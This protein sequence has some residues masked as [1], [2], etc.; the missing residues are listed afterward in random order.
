MPTDLTSKKEKLET[1]HKLVH[2][3]PDL[4]Y[5]VFERLIFHLARYT[6]INDHQLN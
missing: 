2:R 5:A 3:L 1:L 6:F 4:N